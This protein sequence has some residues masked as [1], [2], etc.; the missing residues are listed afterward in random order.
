MR[1]DPYGAY[2]FTVEINDV[3]VGFAE[4]SGLDASLITP[5]PMSR[6]PVTS[7]T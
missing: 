7:P 2:N 4:V 5:R 6:S 3:A 1:V